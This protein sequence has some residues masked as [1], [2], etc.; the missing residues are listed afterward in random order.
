MSP[1]LCLYYVTIVLIYYI[2]EMKNGRCPEGKSPIEQRAI[3]Q[4]L[5]YVLWLQHIFMMG[6]CTF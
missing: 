1:P 4:M 3:S 5:I 6:L 2:T